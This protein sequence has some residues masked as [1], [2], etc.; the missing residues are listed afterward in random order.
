MEYLIQRAKN[1]DPDAFTELMQSHMQTMYKTAR[2]IL[3]SDEDAADA[4]QDTILCCWEK[5][6]QLRENKYFKT[7]MTR[8]LIN[9]C[10]DLLKSKNEYLL[11]DRFYEVAVSSREFDNIEWKETLNTLDEKYRL[12]IILYYVEGFKTGEI[13]QILDI[14]ES[15]VRTRLARGREKMS[16]IY[17]IDREGRATS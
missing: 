4:I 14:P 9:K 3:R 12:V 16:V 1:G 13:S 5:I 15:T 6:V 7:W 11:D 2:S 8:I 17:Q 10:K